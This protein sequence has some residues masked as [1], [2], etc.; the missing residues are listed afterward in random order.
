[1]LRDPFQQHNVS[2]PLTPPP[3]PAATDGD[4]D[5]ERAF[6]A[7]FLDESHMLDGQ[8]LPTPDSLCAAVARGCMPSV[9]DILAKWRTSQFLQD[10]TGGE[11][12]A[13]L[14]AKALRLA[15][16]MGRADLVSLLVAV[17]G[18]QTGEEEMALRAGQIC[19]FEALLWNGWD[20]NTPLSPTGP[21]TLGHVVHDTNLT[22]WFLEHG[23]DPNGGYQYETAFS[24]AAGSGSMEVIEMFLS[25]GADVLRG[26]V[27]FFATGRREKAVEVTELLLSR[28]ADPNRL[29]FDAL[30]PG[31][32]V[33]GLKDGLGTPL[34]YAIRNDRLD[35]VM[36][37]V[38]ADADLSVPDTLGRT[39]R[40][41]AE[42]RHN[43]EVLALLDAHK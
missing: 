10:H 17:R 19:N 43:A 37:L 4:G 39:P 41:L 13:S 21:T 27:L 30:E 38:K 11:I 40:M 22:K 36:A 14:T 16:G 25:R 18:T 28:G 15:M 7:D 1:M 6:I 34:H 9:F 20:I 32:S 2:P 31:W 23:A 26:D 3:L 24:C 29:R 12:H 5:A 8:D 35:V 42:Q 33:F